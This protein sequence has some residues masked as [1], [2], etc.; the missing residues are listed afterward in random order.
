MI[1]CANVSSSIHNTHDKC[2]V[3]VSL[4]L[5]P[6]KLHFLFS[7]SDTSL[8]TLLDQVKHVLADL[9]LKCPHKMFQY[10]CENIFKNLTLTSIAIPV[11]THT[12]TVTCQIFCH[13]N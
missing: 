4:N 2:T 3:F 12:H 10:I 13:V 8:L 1:L 7:N 9:S 5:I 6:G 11:H